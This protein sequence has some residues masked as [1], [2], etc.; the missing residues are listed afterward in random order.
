MSR[1]FALPAWFIAAIAA[2][3][4]WWW[5]GRPVALPDAPSQVIPC[6]SFA[7]YRGNQSVM[8]PTLVIPVEQI[9][10]DLRMLSRYT[11]CVRTYG[12]GQG[13]DRVPEIAER[14]GMKVMLGAWISP[15][16]A[17][18]ARELERAIDVANRFPDTVS[19]LVVGNEVLLRGDLPEQELVE[20]LRKAR[21]SVSVPIT[22]ADVT[23]YWFRHR[24]IADS[25]DFVT[26]HILP[27]WDD[28]PVGVE[29]TM[30]RARTL[31][32]QAREVFPDKRVFVGEA[33]WPSAGRMRGEALPSRVNQARFV[34]ELLNLAESET[35]GLNLIE[36][37][38]QPWKR[39][40]EGTV[41]GYWGLLSE[42]RE[43][44]SPLMGPVSDD[45]SWRVHLAWSV[46]IAVLPLV[47]V[48]EMRGASA[49]MG[50][51][52]L[53]LASQAAACALVV[54]MLNVFQ[55]SITV[56]DWMV[57]LAR[58]SL[59]AAAFALTLT[60]FI[61]TSAENG[62]KPVVAP[63]RDIVAALRSRT[64]RAFRGLD[65]AIGLVRG[66]T[67]FGAAVVTLGLVFDARY[68]DFPVAVYAVPAVAFVVLSFCRR[69]NRAADCRE[70][71]LLAMVLAAGGSAIAL[72]EG[73]ANHQA[74]AWAVVNFI[75]A[76]TVA[77]D[78]FSRR[79]SGDGGD[80]RSPPASR[81]A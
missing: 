73:F 55:T 56:V 44:K 11:R 65:F 59:A 9:E 41:G 32:R 16:A 53:A 24:G 23:D 47:T 69:G 31:W 6:V 62:D 58:W 81:T 49:P 4:F 66:L 78:V 60:A 50:W 1:W 8:D 75:L 30:V 12:V 79:R 64:F 21:N 17:D 38:D 54:A 37:F 76:G 14:F 26:I 2:S 7:P 51:L 57:G 77:Y 13:L 61:K 52:V 46:A 43:E 27:Y 10:D 5:Q 70:E 40:N 39:I 15:N 74:L 63:V 33:G 29:D 25:V 20:Y 80:E 72:L 34:R 28:D 48:L 35:M 19:A 71:I 18:N 68:R 36:A 45:P 67:L 22:Y 42:P 3:A